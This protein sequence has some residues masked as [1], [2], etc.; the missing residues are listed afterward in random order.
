MTSNDTWSWLWRP[1]TIPAA[2][3]K[4]RRPGLADEPITTWNTSWPAAS[5]T[6]IT[7]PGLDGAAISGSSA[8]R[9]MVSVRSYEAPGSARSS[10]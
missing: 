2:I 3:A 5:R 9:S 4:S 10:V 7:L 1:A 6:G 8:D